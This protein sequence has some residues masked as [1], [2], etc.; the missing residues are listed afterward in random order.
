MTRRDRGVYCLD[1]NGVKRWF[2]SYTDPDTGRRV[3]RF[4]STRKSDAVAER[5][6]IMGL[7]YQYD[8]LSTEAPKRSMLFRDLAEQYERDVLPSKKS[9]HRM[10]GSLGVLVEHF[11]DLKVTGITPLRVEAFIKWRRE[12]GHRSFVGRALENA[13]I[14]RDL[15]LLRVV[16]N[17]G[18]RRGLSRGDNSVSVVGLLPEKSTVKPVLLEQAEFERVLDCCRAI[19]ERARTG[20][21]LADVVGFL[22]LTGCRLGEALKLRVEDVDYERETVT[23]HNTKNGDDRTIPVTADLVRLLKR[24]TPHDGFLFGGPGQVN[25]IEKAWARARAAA[26][27]PTLRLHDLRHLAVSRLRELGVPDHAIMAITG[28]KTLRMLDH[29]SHA[30]ERQVVAAMAELGRELDPV[31]IKRSSQAG[32]EAEGENEPILKL[33]DGRE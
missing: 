24:Q 29:Y 7:I 22:R 19:R 21:P 9:A 2:I 18:K 11:G 28:H 4:V 3:R 23:F 1:R 25:R 33:A 30:R 20:A 17:Y 10:R 32:S 5:C 12:K 8:T 15:A 6:R 26:G 14:N 13:T 16:L 27:F 31:V